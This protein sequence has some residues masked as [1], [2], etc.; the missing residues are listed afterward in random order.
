MKRTL[1]VILIIISA[2]AIAQ[3]WIFRAGNTIGYHSYDM[4][5][6]E[7]EV[8]YNFSNGLYAG[9]GYEFALLNKLS[10]AII[11]GIEQHYTRVTINNIEA[12]GYAY[13]ISIPLQLAY[14]P[15]KHWQFFSGVS[16]Q[17][18]L[19]F[20]DFALNKSHNFRYNFDLG[21][22]YHFTPIWSME[23]SHSL[24]LGDKVDAL[25]LKNYANHVSLGIYI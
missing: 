4:H 13:N 11:P 8:Q 9:M 18:Y 17:N 15:W 16:L 1:I 25:L 24:I 14:F 10:L 12:E 23:L 3:G 22:R 6:W 7:Y 19:D 21:L 5:I 2:Q 20:H